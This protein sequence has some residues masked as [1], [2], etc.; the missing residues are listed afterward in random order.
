MNPST[1][2]AASPLVRSDAFISSDFVALASHMTACQRS[3]GRFFI[4]QASLETL[5]SLTT[6]RLI[7]TGALCVLCSGLIILALGLLRSA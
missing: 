7:T 2:R 6:P 3:R 1:A 5:Q 4:L